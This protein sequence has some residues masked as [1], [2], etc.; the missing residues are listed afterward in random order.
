MLIKLSS[1]RSS[2]PAHILQRTHEVIEAQQ[3][4]SLFTN[5]KLDKFWAKRYML[6][7]KF[8]YGIK[9][10]EFSW[11]SAIPEVV[12]EYLAE[13]AKCA[14]VLVGFSGIGSEAIKF[15]NTCHTVL[16]NDKDHDKLE[17]LEHNAVIYGANNIRTLNY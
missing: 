2:P 16:T 1:V 6:F 17:C 14:T 12:S 9:L 7:E 3:G 5:T 10:D 4:K 13:R 15:S 8:D 11:Y